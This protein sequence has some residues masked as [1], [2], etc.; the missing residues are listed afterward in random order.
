MS[1]VFRSKL[2]EKFNCLMEK[3]M[4]IFSNFDLHMC[5]MLKLIYLLILNIT[6]VKKGFIRTL[7][8]TFFLQYR[9]TVRWVKRFF[10][11]SWLN[12]FIL[13]FRSHTPHYLIREC[14][15]KN[16]FLTE[17]LASCLYQVADWTFYHFYS[18]HT[19]LLH[20]LSEHAATKIIF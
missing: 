14:R 9:S 18:G 5:Y 19:T 1:W 10:S 12:I 6:Y 16:N 8:H 2:A 20:I 17:Y 11:S 4:F 3:S 13:L 15:H 7:F